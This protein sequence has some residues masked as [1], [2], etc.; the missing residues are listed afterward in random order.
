MQHF[1]SDYYTKSEIKCC[2]CAPP[3]LISSFQVPKLDHNAES[4]VC[5]SILFNIYILHYTSKLI[6]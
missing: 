3:I 1:M 5:C 6:F 4:H 2:I